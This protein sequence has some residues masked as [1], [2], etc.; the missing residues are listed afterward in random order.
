MGPV[1]MRIVL[2]ISLYATFSGGYK[3]ARTL[4][5][6][7]PPAPPLCTPPF[8]N[9]GV[10]VVWETRACREVFTTAILHSGVI[11]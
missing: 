8:H 2:K 3:L 7:T 4:I 10:I 5:I 11:L 9:T 6:V 1:C